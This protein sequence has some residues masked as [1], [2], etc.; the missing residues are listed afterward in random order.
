MSKLGGDKAHAGGIYGVRYYHTVII[1]LT[2][3]THPGVME[4]R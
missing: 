4:S 2:V 1:Y 3:P